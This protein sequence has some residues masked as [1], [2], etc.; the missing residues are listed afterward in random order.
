MRGMAVERNA[1]VES[2]LQRL[3][4]AI[5]QGL[6]VPHWRK[7]SR[8]CTGRPK[9]NCQQGALGPGASA[10]FM[11]GAVD[12][13]LKLEASPD[14]QR[15]DA[16]WGIELMTGDRQHIDTELVHLG[17]DFSDRLGRI[18]VKTDPVLPSDRADFRDRLYGADFVVGMHDADQQ[19]L[20]SNGAPHVLWIDQACPVHR[21]VGDRSAEPFEKPTG[22][23]NGGVLGGPPDEVR[24][25][26]GRLAKSALGLQ[27]VC[28]AGPARGYAFRTGHPWAV[29]LEKRALDC[30]VVCFAA[31]AG[32]YDFVRRSAEEC[33]DLAASPIQRGLRRRAGPMAAGRIAE[34]VF[35]EWPHRLRH[36]WIN[37]CARVVIEIDRPHRRRH[38]SCSLW[39][40]RS[41]GN[42]SL[43]KK[44]LPGWSS[45]ARSKAPT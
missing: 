19:R 8:Q 27:G 43:A 35:Q 21:N 3:P 31:T 38:L 41:Q 22:R 9:P 33:G 42:C 20:R 34:C 39:L 18:G 4:Q 25:S 30:Q 17:R 15:A 32:E 2:R 13:R 11:T 6:Y 1:F 12:Q 37:R 29:G 16:L 10:R 44:C 23:K 24:P 7:V 40:S 28:F 26:A 5:A 45:A 36:G 14:V